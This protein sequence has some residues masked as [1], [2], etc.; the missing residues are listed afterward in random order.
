[1]TP[2]VALEKREQMIEDGFCV[3]DDVLSEAFLQELH[4]ESERLIAGHV[5]PEDVI[6]QGQHVNVRGDDNVHIKKLLEW[7]PS[8]EALE[9]I[10]FGDFTASGGIIILTKDP[11]GPALYWHQDWMRWN[12][13]LSCAPWPQTIFLNYYLTDTT[14]EN[15]CLKIIP[16]T[17]RKRIDLHD[18]L[19]PAHEQ[20]ARFIEEDHPFMFSNHPDQV[21]VCAKAGSLVIADAR[22]LHSAHKNHTDVRRTLILAWHS[23]PNTIPDYWDREIPEPVAN[24]DENGDYLGSRIPGDFLPR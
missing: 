1:M 11:G 7:E 15:G 6:Y 8:C 18:I 9:Q 14:P 2:E 12:D 4:D 10:G 21:D 23:R 3:I 17:H 19:V 24:R 16:S 20:G 5:Q 13:P 22:I